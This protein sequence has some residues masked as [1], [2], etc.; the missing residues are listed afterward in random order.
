MSKVLDDLRDW[1]CD[2]EGALER[3]IGDAELYEVCLKTVLADKSF[4][5]LG[6]ALNCGDVKAAFDHAH[7]LKGVLA[8]MGLTPMYDITVRI[9]EPLRA[10]SSDDLFPAYEE[11]IQAKEKLAG[12]L[13]S[14]G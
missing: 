14:A 1:G 8:N 7:T 3:F 9:V 12:I 6:K 10:G 11:L 5:E 13:V 2:V 4:A